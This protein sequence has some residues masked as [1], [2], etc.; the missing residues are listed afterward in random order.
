M[1]YMI[2]DY[3]YK[4]YIESKATQA[5]SLKPGADSEGGGGQ[6]AMPPPQTVGLLCYVMLYNLFKVGKCIGLSV[7]DLFFWFSIFAISNSSPPLTKIL[8]PL[9]LETYSNV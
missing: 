9:L 4:L 7:K 2:H 5:I 8:D 6:R 3:S 1:F